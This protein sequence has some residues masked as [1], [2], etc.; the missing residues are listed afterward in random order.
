MNA[1]PGEPVEQPGPG[2][3]S[4]QQEVRTCPVCGT[5]FYATAVANSLQFVS[6]GELSARNLREEGTGFSIWVSSQH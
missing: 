2:L 4:V 1:D 6:N 5:K 3:G